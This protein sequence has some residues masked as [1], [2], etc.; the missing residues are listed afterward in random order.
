MRHDPDI[1]GLGQGKLSFGDSVSHSIA[2][3]VVFVSL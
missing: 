3:G 1:S 2:S